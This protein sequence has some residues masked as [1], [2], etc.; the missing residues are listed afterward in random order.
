M[1]QHVA[2]IGLLRHWSDPTWQLATRY[3]L[4]FGDSQ[5]VVYHA[6]GAA[7]SLV[8]G[9]AESANRVLLA[10]VAIA[11]PYALRS[12]LAAL[13]R[14][15]RLA[16]FGAPAFWSAPLMMG[17]APYVAAVPV[18]VWGIAMFVRQ[19]VAP[20]RGR[21]IALACLACLLF[22]VHASAYL[23][24]LASAGLLAIVLHRE[25]AK[26]A[27]TLAW[28]AP[29]VAL[30]ALW[31]LRGSLAMPAAARLDRGQVGFVSPAGLAR[32]LPLWAHDVWRSH[33][34][35]ACAIVL[36]LA[37]IALLFQR[38]RAPADRW[39]ARAAW[40]PLLVAAL[41]YAVLPYNV[42]AATMLDLRMSTFVVLLAPLVLAP[43]PGLRGTVPLVAVMLGHGAGVVS[44]IVEV[45]RA[46]QEELGD[47]DRLLDRIPANATVLTLPVHLTSAHTHWP[48]WA[49]LGSYHLARAGGAA[50]MSFTE[51]RHWPIRDRERRGSRPLFWTLAP[52][53]FR[54]AIDGPR[55]DYVL[56]RASRDVFRSHP[57][58]PRWNLVD[59]EREWSLYEKEPGAFWP[60]REGAP[61]AG[62]CAKDDDA[63]PV[64][65]S[66]SAE[67]AGGAP[68]CPSPELLELL[69]AATFYFEHGTTSTARE[70]LRL[71]REAAAREPLDATA[72]ET[73]SALGRID[74][75]IDAHPDVAEAEVER[76]RVGFRDWRCLPEELHQ[77]F[78]ASLPPLR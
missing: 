75:S 68:A 3:E 22:G 44:S 1:P 54:N 41:A 77:R 9:S 46:E 38:G 33:V 73:L 6:A 51:I 35:E 61:D 13:G 24:L 78:H 52:C 43:R 31:A 57:P 64:A 72:S 66:P 19:A 8:T 39:L 28:L 32:Q 59:Q 27:R 69:H 5:Y 36:A 23:V 62:P 11:F 37:M 26:I 12:L 21:G 50:E 42:G 60:P 20:S 17:F 55:V 58:G 40:A 70:M 7:L 48:P 56:V 71:A 34:D 25:P 14:D 67:E 74:A 76:V 29:S 47:I 63:P 15:V 18:A 10:V 16:L 65:P 30:A 53:M 49:F 2:A 4:N 45:R